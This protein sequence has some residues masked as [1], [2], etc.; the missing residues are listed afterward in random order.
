V[1]ALRILVA[2]DF[3]LV[4]RGVR[5]L[6]ESHA[7][8]KVVGEAANGREAVDKVKSLKPHV[9]VLDISMPELNGLEATR[10]IRKT[11]PETQILVLTVHESKQ[12]MRS[13]L[14]AGA[15]GYVVKSDAERTLV[16]AVEAL[17]QHRTFVTPRFAG[18]LPNGDLKAS[19]PAN[20]DKGTRPESTPRE[21]GVA[22]L[23]AKGKRNAIRKSRLR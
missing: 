9:V 20:S 13:L 14:E 17:R 6:L 4:R 1:S 10:E 18:T 7:G 11:A 16:K 19:K 22:R 3:A 5:G 23:L 2:D 15:R 8:W 12:V 21:G